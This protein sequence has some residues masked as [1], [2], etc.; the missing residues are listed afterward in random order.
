MVSLSGWCYVSVCVVGKSFLLP[1]SIERES[2]DELQA[3]LELYGKAKPF[4]AASPA[5]T[6]EDMSPEDRDRA[7]YNSEFLVAAHAAMSELITEILSFRQKL[8]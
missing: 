7:S 8:E 3:L 5:R 6:W 4:S 1:I 2:I